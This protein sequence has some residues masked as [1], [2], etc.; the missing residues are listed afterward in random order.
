MAISKQKKGEIHGEES[1][2]NL[3]MK[4]IDK[5]NHFPILSKHILSLAFS[6]LIPVER[7]KIVEYLKEKI[8]DLL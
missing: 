2:E 5:G 8:P 3:A 7:E 1:I 6:S 4:I